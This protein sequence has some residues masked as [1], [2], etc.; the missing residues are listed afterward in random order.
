SPAARWR[1]SRGSWSAGRR[2]KGSWCSPSRCCAGAWRWKSTARPWSR[3]DRGD[4][5]MERPRGSVSLGLGLL[6]IAVL[7]GT[8]AA[9]PDVYLKGTLAV[10]GVQDDNLFSTPDSR[11]GDVITRLTPAIEA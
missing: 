6:G 2:R 7:G 1:A 5:G 10:T 3:P 9:Q 11:Q 8:A 4:R